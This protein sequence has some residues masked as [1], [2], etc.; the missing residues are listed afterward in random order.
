MTNERG[1]TGGSAG[2]GAGKPLRLGVLVV[3]AI[4]GLSAVWGLWD[5]VA[6]QPRVWGWFGFEAVT[7]VASVLGVLV[8]LG[9]P[10]EAP[11]LGTAC[12][13]GAVFAS[14][15]LGR[16]SAIVTRSAESVSEAQAVRMLVRD[17][18][19][20]G[21]ILAA[22]ALGALALVLALRDDGRAWKKLGLGVAAGLP[23]VVV[24]YWA[25]AAGGTQWLLAPVETAADVARVVG[26]LLGGLA[27]VVLASMAVHLVVGAFEVRLPALPGERRAAPAK[28]GAK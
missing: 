13:A 16:F 28:A 14:A 2:P 4:V 22:A 24:L 6:T 11:A 3:S 8:G 10:R 25:L 1:K 7:L 21:R 26:S 5:S 17:P 18:V 12:V 15:T 27:L 23:V 19:F 9:R 20:D